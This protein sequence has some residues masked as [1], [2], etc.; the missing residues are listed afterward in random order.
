VAALVTVLTLGYPV[1]IYLGLTRWNVRWLG[2]AIAAVAIGSLAV[3]LAPRSGFARR[4]THTVD[5]PDRR[6]DRRQTGGIVLGSIGVVALAILSA[7]SNDPRFVLFV[8]VLIS[9]SLL[10]TF[11]VTLRAGAT[12]MIERFARLQE[13]RLSDAELRWCR[14][15]TEIW[16]LFFAVN[17]AIALALALA[18]PAAWW[19]LY[20]G[21]LAY[22][23]IGLL[24]AGEYV[25]RKHR[26]RAFGA[27]P[28]DRV[29]VR[30]LPERQP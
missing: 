30:L 25:A 28:I 6:D 12:P 23:L 7:S 14:G 11:G 15:V 5:L 26:F 21:G 27:S 3:R 1:L 24:V 22:V 18:A 4:G 8:P 10:V 16:C 20:T 13:P 9:A 17:G 2:L 29:L 19:A